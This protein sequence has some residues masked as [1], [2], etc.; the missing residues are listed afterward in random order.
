M[1]TGAVRSIL[2]VTVKSPRRWRRWPRWK[3]STMAPKV[4]VGLRPESRT[5]VV[6]MMISAARGAGRRRLVGVAQDGGWSGGEGTAGCGDGADGGNECA[7][8]P[9]QVCG[10]ARDGF[11]AGGT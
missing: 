1:R 2:P 9:G 10:V 11:V 7:V 5:V 4:A 6:P 8:E 3:T